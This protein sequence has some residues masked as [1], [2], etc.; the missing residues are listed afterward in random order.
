MKIEV[1]QS[2]RIVGDA[3]QMRDR[4]PDVFGSLRGLIASSVIGFPRIQH[5]EHAMRFGVRVVEYERLFSNPLSGVGRIA[6][7]MQ[8]R[9]LRAHFRRLRISRDGFL[10]LRLRAFRVARRLE[11]A[12]EEKVEVGVGRGLTENGAGKRERQRRH[13][14]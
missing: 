2:G 12:C 1:R 6:A 14:Q 4:L 3:L 10:E 9:E 13:D 11:M 8:R 7:Q 5:A